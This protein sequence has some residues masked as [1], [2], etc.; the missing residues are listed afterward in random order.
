MGVFDLKDFAYAPSFFRVDRGR[1]LSCD[2]NGYYSISRPERFCGKVIK[3][4]RCYSRY[5]R[6]YMIDNWHMLHL[7]GVGVMAHD[8]ERDIYFVAEDVVQ[9]AAV[10]DQDFEDFKKKEG[11]KFKVTPL[12]FY[13]VPKCI[14]ENWNHMTNT[15]KDRALD[16]LTIGAL[17]K[18]YLFP[19]NDQVDVFWDGFYYATEECDP[20]YVATVYALE[21]EASSLVF[22]IDLSKHSKFI[23]L[24]RDVLQRMLD[25]AVAG[26]FAGDGTSRSEEDEL[27]EPEVDFGCDEGPDFDYVSD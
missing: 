5:S 27:I 8:K 10:S 16:A 14:P 11:D 21:K 13:E 20:D 25:D 24:L 6:Y 18:M 17:H 15:L 19:K 1:Y 23:S 9:T 12:F 26:V 4:I 2:D 22:H 7:V 3:P